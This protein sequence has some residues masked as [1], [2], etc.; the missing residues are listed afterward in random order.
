MRRAEQVMKELYAAVQ[1]TGYTEALDER[2]DMP[3][4]S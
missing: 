1:E 3:P 2:A 4:S